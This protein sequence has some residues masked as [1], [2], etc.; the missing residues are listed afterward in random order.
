MHQLV[1]PA[2]RIIALLIVVFLPSWAGLPAYSMDYDR[3]RYLSPDELR[4]G[5]KGF[6]R[7]VMSGTKIETF[8]FE[9]ISVM[10]N[11]WYAKQDIILVR[12]SGLNLEHTSIIGG[13]SGSPCY[14][15]GEDGEDRMIGAVAFGWMFNKDPLC[16]LQPI[17]QM[18]DIAKV[19]TPAEGETK[20][21][22]TGIGKNGGG[23]NENEPEAQ[24]LPTA[25]DGSGLEVGDIAG[26]AWSGS[27]P[28]E[29]RFSIFNAD[30]LKRQATKETDQE[31]QG[32]LRPLDIPVMTSGLTK[33]SRRIF[34]PRLKEMG[35][36]LIPAGAISP[37]APGNA[38]K[39]KLEPGSVICIN[40]MTGDLNMTALGT[41]TEV[42]GDKVLGFGHSM[43][44]RG[45]VELP[46]ATG[47][48]HM[49]VP[50]VMRS[51]KIGS[52][53]ATVGTLRGDENTGIFG[54]RG[55]SPRMIPM[56]VLVNDVRGQR[57]YQYEV[58]PDKQIGPNLMGMGL[59][60]SIFAHSEPPE[61][62]H[63]QY[64]IEVQFEGLGTFR[65]TN[66]SSQQEGFP[67]VMDTIMPIRMM[68]LSPFGEAKVQSVRMEMAIKE[69]TRQ[70]MID[71][72]ELGKDVYKPGEKV[73]VRVRLFRRWQKPSYKWVTCELKLPE[74][75]P[76]GRYEL[77]LGAARDYLLEM[78]REKPH[79]FRARTLKEL[80]QVVNLIGSYSTSR[81]YLRLE[82]PK[83]GISVHRI[84]LPELPSFRQRIVKEA[85]GSDAREFQ[86]SLVVQKETGFVI[87]GSESASIKV[88]RK[89]DQ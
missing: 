81:M 54:I 72:M 24:A 47:M 8:K 86:E 64:K 17:T 36:N 71:Q 67:A 78:R 75:L 35:M 57:K 9:V 20:K 51:N 31:D 42:M 46:M 77:R 66:L 34:A 62:H 83:K 32:L 48:V 15:T 43:F 40:M 44:S 73:E 14:V 7:T 45:A 26:L 23:L 55:K 87:Q 39:A 80:M 16:G 33:Q 5:M 70:A 3:T 6:G 69:G 37:A 76:D 60:E 88:S 29:S 28:T 89:A 85:H 25:M 13:M 49:V 61:K 50:S 19:R 41:C 58:A 1:Q 63:I 52:A 84:E 10:R 38:K 12:C 56:S 65:T 82:L 27:L 21:V 22:S 74:D 2:R 18:L 53:V 59:T 4:P 68:Q 11:A 79:L 30:I